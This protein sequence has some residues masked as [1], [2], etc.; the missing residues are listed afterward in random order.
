M[1]CRPA[2]P[3]L[4]Y[5]HCVLESGVALTPRESQVGKQEALSLGTRRHEVMVLRCYWLRK[6]A[7]M[8]ENANVLC[9][10]SVGYDGRDAI[11]ALIAG[12]LTLNN[13]NPLENDA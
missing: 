3:Y 2:A 6:F 9:A 13:K 8:A 5:A 11:Y 4:L 1:K 7:F 12:Y 10:T